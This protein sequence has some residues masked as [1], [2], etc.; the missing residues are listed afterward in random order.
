VH[1]SRKRI[2]ILGR[3]EE[4]RERDLYS[5]LKGGFSNKLEIKS[6]PLQP[7]QDIGLKSRTIKNLEMIGMMMSLYSIESG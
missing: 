6:Q 1:L 3:K 4:T 5:E 7:N 2:K